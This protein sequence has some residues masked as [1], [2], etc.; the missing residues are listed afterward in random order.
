MK[1]KISE[2]KVFEFYSSKPE[3]VLFTFGWIWMLFSIG[4]PWF[5]DK[6]MVAGA[7]FSAAYLLRKQWGVAIRTLTIWAL[8]DF[9][10]SNYGPKVTGIFLLLFLPLYVWVSIYFTKKYKKKQQEKEQ[11]EMDR[12]IKLKS[13][14]YFSQLKE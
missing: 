13:E 6:I 3:R 2:N 5:E 9:I 8:M 10:R 11:I 1:G 4:L 14:P 7:L 12:R